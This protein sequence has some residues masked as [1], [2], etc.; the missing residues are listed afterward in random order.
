MHWEC[1]YK[2]KKN[3]FQYSSREFHSQV[4]LYSRDNSHLQIPEEL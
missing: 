2:K 1:I 3:T 4:D